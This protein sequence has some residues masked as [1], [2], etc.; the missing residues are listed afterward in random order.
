MAQ[1]AARIERWARVWDITY[2][3]RAHRWALWNSALVVV[4]ALL[5]AGAGATGLGKVW[6]S[7][8]GP[9]LLALGAAAV[10]GVTSALGAS[11]RATDYNVAAVSNSS[12][13]DAALIFRTTVVD[14]RAIADV[15]QEFEALCKRRDAVVEASPITGPPIQPTQ[16]E[17]EAQPPTPR[18]RAS[19]MRRI[20]RRI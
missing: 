2:R 9:G 10:S 20:T 19:L 13:A 8:L 15:S 11:R 5:A 4:A 1:E 18:R 17:I 12:L 16:E 14:D 6:A 7:S 3:K